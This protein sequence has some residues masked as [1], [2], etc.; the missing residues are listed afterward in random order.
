MKRRESHKKL[1]YVCDNC[2]CFTKIIYTKAGR[3]E[4]ESCYLHGNPETFS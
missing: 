2:G 3:N 1:Q 4:C